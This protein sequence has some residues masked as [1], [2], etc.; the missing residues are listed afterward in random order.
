MPRTPVDYSKTIIYKL[1]HKDD[2]N[3]ENIYIGSTTS[4]KHRKQ[5]HKNGCNNPNSK[6]YNQKKYQYI[7]ENGG[8]NDWCMIE[9]EKFNCNDF[10]EATARERY[11]LKDLKATLNT[12]EPNRSRTEHYQ[13]NKDKLSEINKQYRQDNK[14]KILGKAKQYYQDN[15]DKILE[16]T[17]QYQ[18]NNKDQI[19]SYHKKYKQDNKDKISEKVKCDICGSEVR[20]DDFKR[21]Q[22]SQKCMTFSIKE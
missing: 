7:R 8:W 14:D 3:D 4:F 18:Q 15:K 1:V 21:H 16:R 12:I 22:R 5:G 9:I 17:K 2:F 19:S 13:D 10:N 11:W 20:K 6:D